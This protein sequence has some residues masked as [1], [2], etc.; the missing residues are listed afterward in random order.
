MYT[1][2]ALIEG[3]VNKGDI[4]GAVLDITVGNRFRFSKSYGGYSDRGTVKYINLDTVFDLASLTKVVATL[5]VVLSLAGEGL[6][7]LDGAVSQYVPEF[8]HRTV[9]IRHLLQHTS[10]LAADLP[11]RPRAEQ[12]RKVLEELWL[13]ELEAG[14]GSRVVYSDLGM[15]LLGEAV[16][17]I[18]GETLDI[19]AK[20]RVFEPLGMKET[21][22]MPSKTGLAR[23]AAATEYVDGAYVTGIVH[24]EKCYHLGGVS[25]S[26]GLFSTAADLTRYCKLW[27]DPEK[28]LLISPDFISEC[29]RQPQQGRGL[30]WEVYHDTG[31]VP[32]SCGTTWPR[33][34]FGHTGFTGTS[35]WIDP[36]HELTVVWLTNAVHLGRHTPIR[37]LRGILHDAV[38]TAMVQDKL[39]GS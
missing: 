3:W 35:L 26:A 1:F 18:C 31:S 38:M 13:A 28:S 32:A 7:D 36:Q 20:K 15:I 22:F 37:K 34:S 33:G 9:T 16:Q 24:D 2:D 21:G 27:L 39:I 14:P 17:R 29:F 23:R 8:T 19:A 5:P 12:G 4:P 11:F 6:L 25:G 10:G 30:G